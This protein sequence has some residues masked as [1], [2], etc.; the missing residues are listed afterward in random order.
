MSYLIKNIDVKED[1]PSTVIISFDEK[2]KRND[3]KPTHAGTFP[4]MAVTG[5]DPIT[6]RRFAVLSSLWLLSSQT[7]VEGTR[8]RNEEC[9][10]S[11]S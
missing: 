5:V 10:D 8:W 6:I 4:Y 2:K 11:I 9:I 7:E 3:F 1:Y